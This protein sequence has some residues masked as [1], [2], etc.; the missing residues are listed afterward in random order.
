MP[1]ESFESVVQQL[2]DDDDWLVRGVAI[3]R[4]IRFGDR[5][6]SELER[7]FDLTFDNKAPIQSDSCAAI[8]RLGAVAVPLLLD[9]LESPDSRQ[10]SRAI[11]L[12]MMCGFRKCS[13]TRLDEQIL[14][15]RNPKM[16]DWG[17]EPELV[18][19]RIHVRLDDPEIQVRFAAACALEE[20]GRH[21]PETIR[22]FVDVLHAGSEHAKN[23]AALRLGR[24]G[25]VANES[26]N[27]LR[28]VVTSSSKHTSLAARNAIERIGCK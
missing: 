21:I 9:R 12:L 23:W 11:E 28:E 10:R 13:S 16:P 25:F 4:I 22:V 15:D 26:C 7:L 1:E 19:S 18:I 20:F 6:A 8:K 24:I 14:D 27:V 17:C 2:H 3:R 5:A